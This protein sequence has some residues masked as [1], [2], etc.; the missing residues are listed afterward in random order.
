MGIR[1]FEY[2]L[3]PNKKHIH[4]LEEQL[5]KGTEVYNRLL[6]IYKEEFLENEIKLG[7]YDLEYYITL[8]RRENPQYRSMYRITLNCLAKRLAWG[9]VSF[10]NGGQEVSGKVFSDMRWHVGVVKN[11][12]QTLLSWI[13]KYKTV[14]MRATNG[15]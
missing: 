8:M 4:R 12:C 1:K 6:T 15:T 14:G 7:R 9:Q 5:R 13:P 10:I 3:Y 2:R 11:K